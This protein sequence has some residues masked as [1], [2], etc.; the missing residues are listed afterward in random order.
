M[1]P[2]LEAT[3][4]ITFSDAHLSTI[5]YYSYR[6]TL[7]A[8]FNSCIE[9]LM[10]KAHKHWYKIIAI[11]ALHSGLF[12][13]DKILFLH[14]PKAAGTTMTILLR[15]HFSQKELLASPPPVLFSTR[16]GKHN[17]YYDETPLVGE[18]NFVTLLRDPVE[19]V[20]SEQ[21]YCVEVFQRDPKI[22]ES[23]RLPPDGDPV[24]SASNVVC[25][26]LSGLDPND[27]TITI[28]SHLTHAKENLE[29]HFY[30]VGIVERME[31]SVKALYTKLGWAIPEELPF[32]NTTGNVKKTYSPELIES[33]KEKN[34]ADI[35][36]Y[37]YAIHIFET[38]MVNNDQNETDK[39][40]QK[41][42]KNPCDYTFD[43]AFD[44]SGWGP[45]EFVDDVIYRWVSESNQCTIDFLL[46]EQPYDFNCRVF[47]QPALISNLS[48][49]VN[50]IPL[51]FHLSMDVD[52]TSTAFQWVDL[53]AYVPAEILKTLLKTQILFSMSQ[54]FD[55]SIP[56]YEELDPRKK[57]KRIHSPIGRFA[58]SKISLCP[59]L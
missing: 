2:E 51:Q 52:M 9:A 49:F 50:R 18:Y 30:F 19:R 35:E 59:Q 57:M 53:R 1:W 13:E 43:Q 11:M 47:I 42:L 33:I 28:E 20:L 38:K 24:E 25:K 46:N 15:D 32:H 14:M 48:V 36:L 37:H 10:I 16:H 26:L 5:G 44:G 31:E 3:P 21:R 7:A 41:L 54:P 58:C 34:W 40:N 22:L 45:R 17:S 8:V 56:L 12:A 55:P 23:H 27:T 29:D 39:E 4:K 6:R